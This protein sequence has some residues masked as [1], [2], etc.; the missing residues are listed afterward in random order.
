MTIVVIIVTTTIIVMVTKLELV[1]AT[2]IHDDD[3]G[4]DGFRDDN[5]DNGIAFT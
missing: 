2:E 3:R 1:H 5:D 4:G